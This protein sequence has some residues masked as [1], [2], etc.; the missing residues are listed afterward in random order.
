MTF[1][2]EGK[3]SVVSDIT[4]KERALH[5][6]VCMDGLPTVWPCS[7]HGVRVSVNSQAAAVARDNS[8]HC[9]ALPLK[10]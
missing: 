8:Q 4:K 3:N 1:H 6:F 2:Q 9:W 5:L 7:R 10:P